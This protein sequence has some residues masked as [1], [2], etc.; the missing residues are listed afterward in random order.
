MINKLKE[1]VLAGK[2]INKE[3]ALELA[4]LS[5]D[6]ILKLLSAA[7]EIK[8]EFMS[9][10]VNM[11]S[12]IN[13]KSGSCSEDCSFCAQSAHHDTEVDTYAL[14]S[15]EKILDKAKEMD[16]AGAK[17]FGI[18]TSGRGIETETE[19]QQILDAVKRIKDETDLEVCAS[20][21][22]LEAEQVQKLSEVGLKRYNHNL[23]TSRN[24]FA[25]I[26][27]THDYQERV[28]TVKFLKEQEIEVCCGGIMGLGESFADRIDLACTLRELDVDSIPL[29]I[30]N[31]V[32]G[33]PL[34]DNDPVTPLEALQTAAIFRF[35][36]PRKNIKLCGG[37]EKNLRDLQSLSL[38]SGVNGLLVGNYLTTDGRSV[39]DDLQMIDD[40]GLNNG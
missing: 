34:E 4:S 3:E 14:L 13:A 6:R 30:L 35:I 20:L 12:I 37:R 22:T 32:A 11:C 15:E 24:Y 36:N 7:N 38:L 33:T 16:Q 19:F 10:E 9:D 29:N 25:E 18:V 40:L 27:S 2:E 8:N 31:A 28:Q 39:Q 26:C 5:Q 21:G 17:H 1:K 23:E